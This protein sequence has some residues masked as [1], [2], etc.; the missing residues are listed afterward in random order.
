[1]MSQSSPIETTL[2]KSQRGTVE[3]NAS[4]LRDLDPPGEAWVVEDLP[5]HIRENFFKTLERRKLIKHVGYKTVE[6]SRVK[7][8]E[9]KQ[10]VWDL[11]M[12]LEERS[13][14]Y[15]DRNPCGHSGFTNLSG[16]PMYECNTCKGR[17]VRSDDPDVLF[18]WPDD[19][20][21]AS[22]DGATADE[23]EDRLPAATAD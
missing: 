8:W 22:P 2:S 21:E 19:E 6:G 1:M 3:A 10:E 18:E 4:K 13:G 5:Q 20:D 23:A 7:K 9:T 14:P 11:L 15:T 17:F 12:E 16:T